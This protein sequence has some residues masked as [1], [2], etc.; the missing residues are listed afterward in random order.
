MTEA[1]R[2][3]SRLWIVA[4]V[5]AI[6]P[7]VVAAVR[8]LHGGYIAL[9]DNALIVVRALDVGTTNTPLLGTWSSA[10]TA[11][12]TNLN[13]PGP[14]MFDLLA[15]PI[16]LLGPSVGLVIG[17]ALINAGSVCVAC[18]AA[19]RAG[20]TTAAAIVGAAAAILAWTMGSSMIIDAW[21][22]NAMVLP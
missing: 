3:D 22:P 1:P 14:L 17:V 16:R 2:Q 18:W 6:I 12:G 8:I 7:I 21:Q 5:A 13:H 15:G 19:R 10:S 11:V 4:L 9:G 20:G